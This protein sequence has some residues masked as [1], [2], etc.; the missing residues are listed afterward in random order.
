[1][2][3]PSGRVLGLDRLGGGPP[4]EKGLWA[5]WKPALAFIGP[6]FVLLAVFYVYTTFATMFIAQAY[7]VDMPIGKQLEA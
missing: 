5:R 4:P 6:A 1:M 3:S 2:D 7:G